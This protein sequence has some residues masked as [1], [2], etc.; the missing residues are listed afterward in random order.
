MKSRLILE[1]AWL[2]VTILPFGA[3]ITSIFDKSLLREM[4]LGFEDDLP[5]VTS[6]KYFGC[7]IGRVANRISNGRFSLNSNEYVLSVNNGPNHLHGGFAGFDKREF[8]CHFVGDALECNYFSG[9]MEEGYPGNLEVKITYILV[10]NQIHIKTYAKSD[11]DT[12]VNLTNHT[13]F[14]LNQFKSSIAEHRL[15]IH[16][17]RVYPVDANGC[18]YDQPFNVENTPFDFSDEKIIAGCLSSNNPQIITAKGLD[19]HFEISGKGLRV[20]AQLSFK[21]VSL[22]VYTD[23]PGIHVY[24][25]NFLDGTDIGYDKTAYDQHA[26][27][28][29]EAQYVP[30]SINFDTT[31]APIVRAGH[32][33]KHLTIFEFNGVREAEHEH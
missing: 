32:I 7:T 13:Y 29:F 33:Q 9:A 25:G 19:H 18:T 12:L 17:D 31:I 5:Y 22:T 6:D 2:R 3:T 28:C 11:A 14:N 15:K 4:V 16:A 8:E 24:T 10:K 26:G 21:D 23:K 1:N 20:A 30:D 27:V